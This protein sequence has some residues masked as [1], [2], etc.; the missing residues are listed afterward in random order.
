MRYEL[1][2]VSYKIAPAPADNRMGQHLDCSMIVCSR[3]NGVDLHQT[4]I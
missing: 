3:W 1:R 4:L 2:D